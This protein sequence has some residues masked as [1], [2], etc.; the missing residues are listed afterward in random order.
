MNYE[1]KIKHWIFL[2]SFRSNGKSYGNDRKI[3]LNIW[4]IK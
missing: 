4:D 1:K 3:G 2:E